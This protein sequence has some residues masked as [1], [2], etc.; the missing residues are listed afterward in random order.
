MERLA[1]RPGSTAK[2]RLHKRP[3]PCKHC[4]AS[5][6]RRS[7]RSSLLCFWLRR[8]DFLHQRLESRIAVQRIEQWIYFDPAD[9]GAVAFLVTLF[10]PAQRFIF[11]VQAEI[12][13]SAQVADYLTVLTYLIELAQPSPRGIL[14]TI[15]SFGLSAQHRHI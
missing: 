14:V 10:E 2:L 11:V 3:R 9:V 5:A 8:N 6:P 7:S 4:A 15:V 13:Q 1:S 12:K